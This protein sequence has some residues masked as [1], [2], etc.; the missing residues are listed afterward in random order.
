MKKIVFFTLL[1]LAIVEFSCIRETANIPEPDEKNTVNPLLEKIEALGFD[2]NTTIDFDDEYYLVEGDILLSKEQLKSSTNQRHINFKYEI[3]QKR[4]IRVFLASNKHPNLSKAVDNAINAYNNV[5]GAR[6]QMTRSYDMFRADIYI[7][8]GYVA[9][10]A[11]TKI[12]LEE[13]NYDIGIIGKEIKISERRVEKELDISQLTY[14]VVH[15]LGHCIGRLHDNDQIPDNRYFEYVPGSPDKD[16][17]SV[18]RAN[19]CGRSLSKFSR[20]DVA[21]IR[22]LFPAIAKSEI[23]LAFLKRTGSTA[24]VGYI[25]GMDKYQ[26]FSDNFLGI[27]IN[28]DWDLCVNR[29]SANIFY[30]VHKK[31][32]ASGK[33]EIAIT[34]MSPFSQSVVVTP[35]HPTNANWTFTAGD[36]NR[37]GKDDILCINRNNTAENK[38]SIHILNGATYLTSWILHCVTPLGVSNSNWDF[39]SGDVNNDGKIDV[40]C[41]NKQNINQ[42]RTTIHIL[43]G[44]TNYTTWLSHAVTPL[45]RTGPNFEFYGG[46]Y[47][48][49][50]RADVYAIKKWNTGTNS[51]E[52]HI[53]NGAN[54]FQNFLVQIGTPLSETSEEFEFCN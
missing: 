26:N 30:G 27:E 22:R 1:L 53:L 4:S 40:I 37:D 21:S 25:Y 35:L 52:I 50:G 20:W 14:L 47:N 9:E 54:N 45:H 3:A 48:N 41:I 42:D 49:D 19:E 46:D 15:E 7:I 34:R 8:V 17:P 16:F 32:T 2:K 12:D 36:F 28:N 51:T 5:Q 31:N 24:T 44:A 23:S 11:L 33:T 29:P 13:V 38:T 39:T 10:C 43:N 18:M 6:L